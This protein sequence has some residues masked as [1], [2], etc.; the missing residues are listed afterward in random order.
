MAEKLGLTSDGV[1]YH[2]T[3]LKNRHVLHYEGPT[4]KGRWVIDAARRN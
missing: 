1:K 4:K 2:L 3:V